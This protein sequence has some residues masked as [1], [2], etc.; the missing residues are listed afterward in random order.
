[1]IEIHT[2]SLFQADVDAL[3][4]PVNCVGVMGKG[5]ALAFKRTFPVTSQRYIRAARAGEVQIGRICVAERP[6][7]PRY[8]LHVPTKKHW[9][10]RSTLE[11]VE[12][13]ITALA[14][15]VRTQGVSSVA[16]P[17]LGCGLGGLSWAEVEPRIRAAF[18]TMPEVKVMLFPPQG[19]AGTTATPAPTRRARRSSRRS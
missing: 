2:T 7:A 11:D 15:T 16:I 14:E 8:I 6:G 5:L 13:G 18:V 17:A 10:S 4:N 1:M 3:V 19:A 12:A 9:R